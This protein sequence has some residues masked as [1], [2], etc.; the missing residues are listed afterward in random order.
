[1]AKSVFPVD[2]VQ[3]KLVL[4]EYENYVSRVGKK[5][6]A[7]EAYRRMALLNAFQLTNY[8]LAITLLNE[9]LLIPRTPRNFAGNCKL[10]L[11]DIYLLKDEPWEAKILYAQVEKSYKGPTLRA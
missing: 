7:A 4:K 2:T 10:D 9:A 11:G 6:A 5:R 1:M 3:I 8:D